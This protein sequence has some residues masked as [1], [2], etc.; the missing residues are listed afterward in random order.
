MSLLQ[1]IELFKKLNTKSCTAQDVC[2]YITMVV[3]DNLFNLETIP[4]V[5]FEEDLKS[6]GSYHKKTA[7][8]PA[9]INISR[10]TIVDFLKG[11]IAVCSIIDVIGHELRHHLQYEC[12]FEKYIEQN[13]DEYYV[14][15]QEDLKTNYRLEKD[16]QK[17]LNVFKSKVLLNNNTIIKELK[18][19]P[20]L[21]EW[22]DGLDTI[23][24]IK[25]KETVEKSYY[26]QHAIE[27]DARFGGVLF[28]QLLLGLY[29]KQTQG[30][31]TEL[32][33]YLNKAELIVNKHI[34]SVNNSNSEYG[35][36]Q[37]FKKAIEDLSYNEIVR[38][39][40]FKVQHQQDFAVNAFY[41]KLLDFY[42]GRLVKECSA[43]ELEVVY[44]EHVVSYLTRDTYA[45]D[46][47]EAQ[48]KAVIS[49]KILEQIVC[50][51]LDDK[52]KRDYA[53]Y[54]YDYMLNNYKSYRFSESDNFLN[55]FYINGLLSSV[56][57]KKLIKNLCKDGRVYEALEI[58]DTTHIKQQ[59]NPADYCYIPML[60]SIKSS[61]EI[62][63]KHI[64]D[65]L[66]SDKTTL[67]Q[68]QVAA[69]YL[70]R[71]YADMCDFVNWSAKRYGEEQKTMSD[72][73]CRKTGFEIK[74]LRAYQKKIID[75][76]DQ[77]GGERSQISIDL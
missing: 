73:L 57:M 35:H 61:W 8:K 1:Q 38:L 37:K 48:A 64:E 7:K 71:L 32:N 2:T 66:K 14:K 30:L 45:F 75:K 63:T 74:Y 65:L 52:N 16:T 40:L 44:Y 58:L 76:Y 54:L 29:R 46:N 43:E 55:Y 39:G 67:G 3:N 26:L 20:H 77:L 15:I 56:Q 28:T 21:N 11:R 70:N 23:D 10:H 33:E 69:D 31:D 41:S 24:L 68:L 62:I 5:T 22:L 36:Y 42:A 25:L 19:I 6:N 47:K 34:D 13:A 72:I 27:E 18:T 49:S 51:T 53:E 4:K 12:D 59:E 60:K 17:F 50:S 9:S